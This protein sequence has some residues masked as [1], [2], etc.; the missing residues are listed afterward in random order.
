MEAKEKSE[1]AWESRHVFYGPSLSVLGLKACV[2]WFPLVLLTTHYII[3]I[4][5]YLVWSSKKK[6]EDCDNF[7]VEQKRE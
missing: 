3:T 6:T 4:F 7:L 2:S 1:P 5:A